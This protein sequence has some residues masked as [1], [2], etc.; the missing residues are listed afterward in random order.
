MS[1][2]QGFRIM[3]C[4]GFWSGQRLSFLCV[5]GLLNGGTTCVSSGRVLKDV[6]GGAGF[7]FRLCLLASLLAAPASAR[8]LVRLEH[9]RYVPHYS[10]DGDSF[11][12]EHN[13]TNLLV[14]LYYA[15]CPESGAGSSTDARRVRDQTR[16]FGLNSHRD[17]V[18]FGKEATKFT[19]EQLEEP[20]EIWTA[21]ATA[22]G[23]SVSRRIYVFVRTAAGDDL[24]TLL[25]D[26]G[27]ARAYGVRRETPEGVPASEMAALLQDYESAAMLDRQGIWKGANSR[28]L[29]A[30]RAES[31]REAAELA[32]ISDA[33]RLPAGKIDVNTASMSELRLLPG[34]GAV[35]A[36]RIV[37]M[38]PFE[39]PD[40]LLAVPRITPRSITNISPHLKWSGHQ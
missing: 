40:A 6:S 1:F 2:M 18:H 15:D 10:N 20:F 24:A 36:E 37:A 30:L 28:R 34:I 27:L 35:T 21:F 3:R 29:I 25:V 4:F 14:R 11:H 8:E 12:V 13:G 19:R 17:T 16:Y 39:S 23:R 22:P 31:R 32:A 7:A 9:V 33:I 38:R 26:R 5:S